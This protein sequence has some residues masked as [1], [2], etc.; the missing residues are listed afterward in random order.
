M[1]NRKNAFDIFL[2]KIG[3]Q[4]NNEP[5]EDF[6]SIYRSSDTAHNHAW[7]LTEDR[8]KKCIRVSSS[9][10]L[11]DEHWNE[12]GYELVGKALAK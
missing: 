7:K 6:F 2:S 5:N 11:C 1:K 8:L 10:L 3:I 12:L 4:K 9:F